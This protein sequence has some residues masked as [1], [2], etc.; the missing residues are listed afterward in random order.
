MAR[1]GSWRGGTTHIVM[2]PLEFMQRLATLTPRPRLH[3]MR[4]LGVLAPDA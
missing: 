4:L 3:L 1:P 2:P